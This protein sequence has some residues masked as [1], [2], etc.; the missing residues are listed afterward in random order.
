[1]SSFLSIIA[2]SIIIL[3]VLITLIARLTASRSG[4]TIRNLKSFLNLR[5][6]IGLT[7]EEGKRL[8]ISLGNMP[9]NTIRSAASFIALTS[10]ENILK[11]SS[12]SDKPPIASSGAG[13]LSILSNDIFISTYRDLN[14]LDRFDPKQSYLTGPTNLSYISG[15]YPIV[16]QNDSSV[17]LLIGN[18]GP[19]IGL[20]TDAC[21][22]TGAVSI[23]GTTSLQGQAVILACADEAAIGEEYFAL[24]H[25]LSKLPAYQASLHLQDVLRWGVIVV[26]LFGF[27]LKLLGLL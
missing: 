13:D 8:H 4:F 9:L 17:H 18:Y 23:A 2:L 5:K 11:Q 19:E 15:L 10:L 27:L 26:M 12:L 1:M 16:H 24:P 25:S 21:R 14:A 3:S 22:R 20:I 6:N 7:I